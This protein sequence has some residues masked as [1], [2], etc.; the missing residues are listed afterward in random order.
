MTEVLHNAPAIFKPVVD[1]SIG[2][3]TS[4]LEGGEESEICFGAVSHTAA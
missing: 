4:T 2:A 3:N 1:N